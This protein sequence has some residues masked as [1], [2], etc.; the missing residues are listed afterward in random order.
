[1]PVHPD[2]FGQKWDLQFSITP[3]IPRLVAG[4]LLEGW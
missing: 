3:V 1:M 2:V 4:N